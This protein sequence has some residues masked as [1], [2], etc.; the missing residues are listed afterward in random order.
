MKSKPLFWLPRFS[1][2]WIL[3][4]IWGFPST[5]IL[6]LQLVGLLSPEHSLLHSAFW[7]P[8]WP[9]GL[10]LAITSSPDLFPC[11]W[12]EFLWC[13]SI[14]FPRFSLSQC[15]TYCIELPFDS[16]CPLDWKPLG[17]RVWVLDT[18]AY[19]ISITE[20]GSERML[21]KGLLHDFIYQIFVEYLSCAK[22]VIRHM[23]L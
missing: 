6:I 11:I 23:I 5:A 22:N 17:V 2:I 16:V 10:R 21:S 7:V 1:L 3:F 9:S 19:S 8:P 4:T 15:W 14:T 13:A 20:P 12:V 18:I